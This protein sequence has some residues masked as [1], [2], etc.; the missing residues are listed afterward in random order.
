MEKTKQFFS[1]YFSSE[2][3]L[4]HSTETMTGHLLILSLAFAAFG[5]VTSQLPANNPVNEPWI[6]PIPQ[7][8]QRGNS[9]IKL[10][11]DLNFVYNGTSHILQSA[12]DRY[13][14]LIYLNDEYPMIPY[15]WSTTGSE[16][17]SSLETIEVHIQNWSEELDM[18]TDE[19]YTLTIPISGNAS[20]NATTVFGALRA[21]ET[22]SQIVQWSSVHNSTLVPN[23][24]WRITGIFCSEISKME[25]IFHFVFSI[26]DFPKYKHRGLLLDTSRHYY[27]PRDMFK[28]IDSTW[29][30]Y[31]MNAFIR[32]LT[33]F[34]PYS[35]VVE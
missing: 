29:I 6:W 35:H 25:P 20:F 4:Q 33:F 15:N 11:N 2:G 28:V 18:D 1:R 9:T 13:R 23:V 34:L 22:L 24:P 16:V 7:Q 30:F 10:S 8:W 21:I 5:T 17:L 27:K 19:S 32:Y 3:L 26:A 12:I 31:F 14:K